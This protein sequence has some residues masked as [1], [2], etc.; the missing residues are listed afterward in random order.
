MRWRGV[1]T[2]LIG[3]VLKRYV[4]YCIQYPSILMFVQAR[5]RRATSSV[6]GT[7]LLD[8]FINTDEDDPMEGPAPTEL[9]DI[10]GKISNS[11]DRNAEGGGESTPVVARP[12]LSASIQDA[13]ERATADLAAR[14][15]DLE[16]R[17]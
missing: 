13:V 10:D 15:S 4:L 3:S 2:A 16:D 17:E 6:N 9:E 5:M 12:T 1:Y 14:I 11:I 7:S 8:Q